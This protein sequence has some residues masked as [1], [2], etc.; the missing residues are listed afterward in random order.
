MICAGPYELL[1]GRC[2]NITASRIDVA[3]EGTRNLI[4]ILFLVFVWFGKRVLKGKESQKQ[5]LG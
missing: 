2:L 1:V 5:G 4:L 3:I